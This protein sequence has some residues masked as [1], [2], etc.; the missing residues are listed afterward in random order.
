VIPAQPIVVA[1]DWGSRGIEPFAVLIAAASIGGIVYWRLLRRQRPP[2]LSV[3]AFTSAAALALAAFAP[4]L[5]SSDVYAYAAYGEMARVGLNPYVRAPV[6]SSDALIRAAEAQWISTFPI[7]VYGPGFVGLA[8]ATVTLLSPF[9][10]LAQLDAFRAI[11]A[12]ALLLCII[13]AHGAYRGDESARR[14]AAATIGLNPV[15]IWCASEGHN[16]ALAL[17]V[18]LC[19][20]VLVRRRLIQAGAAVAAL[21][22]LVKP[23]GAIAAVALAVVNPRARVGAAAGIAVA[24]AFSFPLVAGVATQ[25]AP[26]GR[27]AP[28]VSLQAVFAPLGAIAALAVAGAIAAALVFA[29]VRRL[30]H[31]LDEGWIWLGVAAWSLVPNPYPWYALWLLALAGIA[32][33]TRA[34]S[35]TILLSFTSLLRYLP[36]ATATPAGPLAVALGIVAALPLAGLLPLR[37]PGIISNSHDR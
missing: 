23:P 8:R 13:F 9:G 21:S 32:P 26:H 27:Y 18:V 6:D 12:A 19:G 31:G 33:R 35:V 14:L 7:C 1:T 16:D 36:D 10:A 15:A 22:A 34:A 28:Q 3:I 37:A 24:A 20:F 17:A 29:G 5:F 2:S 4:V 30:R 11:A 25:L